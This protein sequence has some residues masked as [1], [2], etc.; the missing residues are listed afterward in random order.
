[1]TAVI[2]KQD[3]NIWKVKKNAYF[4]MT[5]HKVWILGVSPFFKWQNNS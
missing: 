4:N 5:K 3:P 2:L 1:M